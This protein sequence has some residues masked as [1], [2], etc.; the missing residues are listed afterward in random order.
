MQE[1]PPIEC[2]FCEAKAQL[3]FIAEEGEDGMWLVCRTCLNEITA[4]R[5]ANDAKTL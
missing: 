4:E 5:T 1:N 3:L 2:I